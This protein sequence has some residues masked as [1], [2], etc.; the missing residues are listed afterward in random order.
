MQFCAVQGYNSEAR[1]PKLRVLSIGRVSKAEAQC[2]GAPSGQEFD[3]LFGAEAAE[4]IAVR[5]E[6]Y[7]PPK[8]C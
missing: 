4:V 7:K 3:K 1:L 8:A 2:L 5:F 6:A